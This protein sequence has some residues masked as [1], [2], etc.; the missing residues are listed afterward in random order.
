MRGG[1]D[2][3]A[4]HSIWK[5]PTVSALRIV[6]KVSGSS[7]GMVASGKVPSLW[8]RMR[9][10]DRWMTV[11]Q[12][13]ESEQIHQ[14]G[15]NREPSRGGSFRP[16]DRYPVGSWRSVVSLPDKETTCRALRR[17]WTEDSPFDCRDEFPHLRRAGS[18]VSPWQERHLSLSFSGV[19]EDAKWVGAHH[20]DDVALWGETS[21]AIEQSAIPVP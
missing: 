11:S 4:L 18:E 3:C 10:K 6:A 16:S 13:A 21:Q 2:V 20:A 12:H 7:L 9:R 17:V 8:S 14:V 15:Q 1:M 5:T 19:S